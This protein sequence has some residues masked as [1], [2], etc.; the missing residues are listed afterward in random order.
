MLL[1]SGNSCYQWITTI[2]LYCFSPVTL[3]LIVILRPSYYYRNNICWVFCIQG[4]HWRRDGR[5]YVQKMSK[6][7]ILFGVTAI[8]SWQHPEFYVRLLFYILFLDSAADTAVTSNLMYHFFKF[9]M[10]KIE[11][12]VY[13]LC[14]L[15]MSLNEL[16]EFSVWSRWYFLASLLACM[17]AVHEL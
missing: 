10:L 3:F 6:T 5:F 13:S 16:V 1:F 8:G 4:F 9:L 14:V 2:G 15:R 7:S 17:N 11:A 12:C